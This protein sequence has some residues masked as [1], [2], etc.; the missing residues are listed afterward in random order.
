MTTQPRRPA[1][2]IAIEELPQFAPRP[3]RWPWVVLALVLVALLGNYA[4]SM[5]DMQAVFDALA[6]TATVQT[7]FAAPLSELAALEAQ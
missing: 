7:Q 2:L 1:G 6:P 4:W 5:I 3:R